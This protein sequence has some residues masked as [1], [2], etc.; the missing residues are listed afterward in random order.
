MAGRFG[1]ASYRATVVQVA[2]IVPLTVRRLYPSTVFLSAR[3]IWRGA[4][5]PL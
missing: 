3:A 2:L 1:F 4:G 5:S